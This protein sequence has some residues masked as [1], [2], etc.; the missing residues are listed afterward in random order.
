[1]AL[2]LGKPLKA[3]RESVGL[4][5]EQVMEHGSIHSDITMS[6]QTLSQH[7]PNCPPIPP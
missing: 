6:Q 7:S 5:Q 4:T 3:V 1:M 2:S